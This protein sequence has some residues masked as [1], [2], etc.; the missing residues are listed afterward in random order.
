[1][2]HTILLADD[3]VTI[4]RVVELAFQDTDIHVDAVGSGSEAMDRLAAA[5]P[6]LV[7]ADVVLPSPSGYDLCLAVKH[8]DRPVPVLLLR[9][10]FEPFDERR[11]AACGA[12]GSVVKPFEAERLVERV[13]ALLAR[14]LAVV[15]HGSKTGTFEEAEEA[16]DEIVDVPGP[17]PA[18][19]GAA[20]APAAISRHVIEPSGPGD[21][22][23]STIVPDTTGAED[24][25]EV[26]V[27]IVAGGR[28]AG[29]ATPVREADPAVVTPAA[30][31]PDPALVAAVAREVVRRMSAHVIREI[32]WEVVPDLAAVLIRQRLREIERE[33][34]EDR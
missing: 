30:T 16:I 22:P 14:P 5:P 11:A 10:A 27:R 32:A 8:S 23:E 6:D 31:E 3:S 19:P 34:P 33:D 21:G 18:D 9:G 26:P 2:P 29:V 24:A 17:P 20:H 12:D 28:P 13:R 4:R 15:E 25:T 1:M 7:L